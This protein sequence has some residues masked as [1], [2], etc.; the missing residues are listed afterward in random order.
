MEIFEIC[1]SRQSDYGLII[2]S[3]DVCGGA[4]WEH[5]IRLFCSNLAIKFIVNK[6]HVLFVPTSNL[7]VNPIQAACKWRERERKTR[8]FHHKKDDMNTFTTI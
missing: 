2:T 4:G 5:Y 1:P 6:I 8:K 7:C 3:D